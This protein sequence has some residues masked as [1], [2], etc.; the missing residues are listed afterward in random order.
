M[1]RILNYLIFLST[2]LVEKIVISDYN[3]I[4]IFFIKKVL[5]GIVV[6]KNYIFKKKCTIY[7]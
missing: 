2:I 7:F 1:V 6:I 5:F 3:N 4:S